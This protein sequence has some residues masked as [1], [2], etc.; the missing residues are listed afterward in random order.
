MSDRIRPFVRAMRIAALQAGDLARRLQGQVVNRKKRTA[1]GTPES[2]ALTAAD[3]AAQDVILHLLADA[4]PG[5]SVDAEE[6]TDTVQLFAPAAA[7]R[8]E[9]VVDPIDGTF[10]YL[11]GS[12][13]FAVMAA[14][15]RSGRLAAAVVAYPAHGRLYWAI[16]GQGCFAQPAGAAAE[17]VRLGDLPRRVL[18]TPRTPRGWQ[19][20]LETAGYEVSR[21]PCSAVSSGAPVLGRGCSVYRGRADRRRTIALLLTSEAGGV[22]LFGER[23]WRGEDPRLLPADVDA[24]IAAGTESEA[25]SLLSLVRGASGRST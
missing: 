20:A 5:I 4:L 18:V 16:A 6:D 23:R 1:S 14:L 25:R 10:S 21:C 9:V 22:A 17:R 2:E 19:D 24:T 13:D 7:G 11:Q 12:D 8:D 3:L 15:V